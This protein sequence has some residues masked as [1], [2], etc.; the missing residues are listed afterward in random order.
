MK[1]YGKDLLL[2]TR[3]FYVTGPEMLT[4]TEGNVFKICL[5]T[6]KTHTPNT[7]NDG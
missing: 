5:I 2:E 3:E 1:A 4:L 7:A 6:Q